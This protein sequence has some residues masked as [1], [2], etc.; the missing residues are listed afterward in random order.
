MNSREERTEELCNE[1]CDFRDH[2]LEK[3]EEEEVYTSLLW[4]VTI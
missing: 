4:A 1:I 3:F 2:L